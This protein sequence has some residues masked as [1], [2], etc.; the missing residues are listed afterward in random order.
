V[1]FKRL[2]EVFLTAQRLRLLLGPALFG[3]SPKPKT[4]REAVSRNVTSSNTDG[5]FKLESAAKEKS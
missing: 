1:T 4:A 3:L 2:G 5:I